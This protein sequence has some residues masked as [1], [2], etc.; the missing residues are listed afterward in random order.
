MSKTRTVGKP[1]EA[2][3]TPTGS[4]VREALAAYNRQQQAQSKPLLKEVYRLDLQAA[5]SLLD[6]TG[7]AV[8][9]VTWDDARRAK[10]CT[11]GFV[12]V[13]RPA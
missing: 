3:V 5:Q 1:V 12:S 2:T 11:R 9:S 8:L 6:A 4:D 13:R 10:D 7:R